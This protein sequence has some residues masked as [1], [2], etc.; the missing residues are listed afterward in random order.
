MSLLASLAFTIFAFAF[1]WL[2]F[3][4]GKTM[5]NVKS[6]RIALEHFQTNPSQ[7]STIEKYFYGWIFPLNRKV[8]L[9]LTAGNGDK[10]MT[11][12]F[13]LSGVVFM[14]FAIFFVIGTCF[15]LITELTA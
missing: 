10:L 1:S 5:Y 13:K 8:M 12:W 6:V 15:L 4:I 9:N 11:L 7:G 14:G 3:S 2:I